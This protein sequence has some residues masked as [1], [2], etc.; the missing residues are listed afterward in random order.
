[1]PFSGPI[2]VSKLLTCATTVSVRWWARYASGSDAYLNFLIAQRTCYAAR[3]TLVA[4]QLVEA[5]NLVTPSLREAAEAN[6]LYE[7]AYVS[8]RSR[9]SIPSKNGE[10]ISD[11]SI[12]S[13]NR[14]VTN[15]RRKPA[16][17]LRGR[18]VSGQ[19]M[20][21][22]ATNPV[23]LSQPTNSTRAIAVRTHGCRIGPVTRL[24]SPTDIGQLIKPFVFLD[25]I[26]PDGID[27]D[28]IPDIGK[29][30]GWHPHSGIA[31]VS[32]LFDGT[33][34]AV[35]STGMQA[36]LESGAVDWFMAGGGAWHGGKVL[37]P[38][39]G[40]QL[41]VAMPPELENAPARSRIYGPE[42]FPRKGPARVILGT[43]NG[44]ESPIPVASPMIYLDVMLKAGETWR[45][46]PP[47][48]YEIAWLAVHSGELLASEP[49]DAGELVVFEEAE[50]PVQLD[51]RQDTRLVFGAA[52]KHPY[53]LVLGYYSVHTSAEAL[54]KGERNYHDLGERLRGAGTIQ[55]SPVALTKLGPR[56]S[57]RPQQTT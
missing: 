43:W 47:Q 33:I 5:I 25:G 11:I 32:L 36:D 1:L 19:T 29:G 46:E 10:D 9:I 42:H 20:P 16:G 28:T 55:D 49:V 6:S 57:D 8:F 52:V 27:P 53:D 17:H 35:D 18:P 56:R 51:A 7:Q 40:Y 23:T 2:S 39:G 41:W 44:I 14:A 4:T 45:F 22:A 54:A 21:L 24:V 26:A 34:F 37:E 50:A 38:V 30:F 31:T 48:G 15:Y 13:I 3:Q 12:Y